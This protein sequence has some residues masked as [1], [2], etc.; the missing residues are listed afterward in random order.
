MPVLRVLA[1]EEETLGSFSEEN[2]PRLCLISFAFYS[3]KL[4]GTDGENTL[5]IKTGNARMLERISFLNG[6][7]R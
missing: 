4:A 1:S 2:K 5:L 7:A 6:E 3:G